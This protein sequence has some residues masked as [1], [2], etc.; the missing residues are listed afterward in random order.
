MATFVV[1]NPN[2]IAIPEVVK[3][4]PSNPLLRRDI[5][6]ATPAP[7]RKASSSVT[8]LSQRTLAN[9][10][11]YND[12]RCLLTGKASA[13]LQAC[14][15]VNTIRPKNNP[16]KE[17]LKARIEHVL[18]RQGF[19]GLRPF[20]LDSLANCVALDV[21]SRGQ[22]D[23][24][25]SFCI[26]VPIKQIQDMIESLRVSND[27]WDRRA[28]E[29]RTAPRDLDTTNYPF[30]VDSL[31]ILVLRPGLLLPENEP[32][33][34]NTERPLRP[35]GASL[36]A[37]SLFTS[38]HLHRIVP[39]SPLLFN[40]RTSKPLDTLTFKTER[41]VEDALSMFSLLVNAYYKLRSVIPSPAEQPKA[42]VD[43]LIAIKALFALIFCATLS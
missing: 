3:N 4:P 39:G 32:I 9:R 30:V 38:W 19:N 33:L 31:V 5:G 8:S 13:E 16:E 2:I 11:L 20:A 18:T 28:V 35:R 23:R 29:N 12:Q 36:P 34:I 17:N 7:T 42:V 24:R 6:N 25:G 41:P 37:A 10:V 22:L 21:H 40:I 15:M 14:H 27:L 1:G 26:V 43:Y